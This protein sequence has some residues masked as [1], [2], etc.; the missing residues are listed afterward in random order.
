MA[1]GDI[2]VEVLKEIRDEIRELRVDNNGR[3]DEIRNEVHAL[4]TEAA[5]RFGVVETA[6]LDLAEQHR[7]L[8]RSTRAVSARDARLE[9]RVN[10]LEGRVEKLESK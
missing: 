6:L 3:F 8:V 1:G 5:E 2:T 4:R 9:P 10:S 7:F